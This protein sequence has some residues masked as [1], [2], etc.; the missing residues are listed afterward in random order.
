[1]PTSTANRENKLLPEAAP[2]S[3]GAEMGATVEQELEAMVKLAGACSI[4]L[5]CLQSPQQHALQ[6]ADDEATQKPPLR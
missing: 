1:M 6:Q 3:T 2:G 4:R 5:P